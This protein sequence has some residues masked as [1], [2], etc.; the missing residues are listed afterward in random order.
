MTQASTFERVNEY[1]KH[2]PHGAVFTNEQVVKSTSLPSGN[3]SKA[4]SRLSGNKQVIQIKR[5]YWVRPRETPYG[6]ISASTE[7]IVRAIERHK[8][9]LAVPAGAAAANAIGASTQM[10]L[11]A[12]YVTTRRV[13]SITVGKHKVEFRYSKSLANAATQLSGLNNHEKH[14][15][16]TI[17]VALQYLGREQAQSCRKPIEKAVSALTP[18]ARKKLRSTLNGPLAWARE[19]VEG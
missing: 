5:G 6:R 15:A 16:A 19:Y 3:V 10:A 2:R 4:L 17:R 8:D 11:R 12:S 9:M 1:I 14:Q 7:D 13:D 18:Q